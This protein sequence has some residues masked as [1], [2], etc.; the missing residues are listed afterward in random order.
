MQGVTLYGNPDAQF[1]VPDWGMKKGYG[2]SPTY[3]LHFGE[4][5]IKANFAIT[6]FKQSKT[7]NR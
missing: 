5:D 2:V 3:R 6:G 7:N 1:L 4:L